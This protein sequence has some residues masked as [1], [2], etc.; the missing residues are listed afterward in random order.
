MKKLK[1]TG[2]WALLVLAVVV[3]SS[4][5]FL[6]HR[7]IHQLAVYELPETPGRF[8]HEQMDYLV[9]N[10][11]RADQRRSQDKTEAT[12]H[13]ID[14]EKFGTGN[15]LAMPREWDKAVAKFTKDSLL[16]FG[17]LPY[18][19]IYMKNKLTEA[20][21]NK[22]KDSVLFYAADIGHY[23]SDAHVPLHTTINYDGQLTGQKGLHSL[24]ESMIPE[25]HLNGYDLSS[26]H[27][28]TYLKDP[29]TV[30]W[31][32]IH[33]TSLLVPDV[34]AKEKELTAQF[35]PERKYRTQ[36]RNGR[37]SKSY[38]T[39]FARAYAK[40]LG[41]TVNQQLIASANLLADFWYTAWVDGGKPDLSS[42]L[43]NG[44][45]G[46]EA[47]KQEKQAFLKN[48]LLKKGWLQ[49]RKKNSTEE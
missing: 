13:F 38:T 17:Y 28:A 7:T 33:K 46:E 10:A 48:E 30:V 23:I 43:K 15:M 45:G 12:K 26:T 44:A 14:L 2:I 24:W 20:F 42:W 47:W 22:D 39:E 32:A 8:F 5:G 49:S 29:V 1:I 11:P 31:N 25:I 37:E 36:M 6:V 4:W 18:H 16:E 19:I 40:S 21:R 34:L 3:L 41:N 27:T 35:T 9:F